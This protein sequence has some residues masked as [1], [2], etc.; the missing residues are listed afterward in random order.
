M[1][2]LGYFKPD[3]SHIQRDEQV[4]DKVYESIKCGKEGVYLYN[5]IK[6]NYV[7]NGLPAN[8]ESL[9]TQKGKDK[10]FGKILSSNNRWVVNKYEHGNI[11]RKCQGVIDNRNKVV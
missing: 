2:A 5:L 7:L 1:E 9:A 8:T 11:I 4:L 10:P 3:S 6:F